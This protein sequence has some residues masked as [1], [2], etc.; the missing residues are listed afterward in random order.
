MI[1]IALDVTTSQ[2]TC[3]F[4]CQFIIFFLSMQYLLIPVHS[5]ILF[6]ISVAQK[7]IFGKTNITYYVHCLSHFHLLDETIQAEP[8]PDRRWL[9]KKHMC[10]LA[11]WNWAIR[12]KGE[13]VI[14]HSAKK[15][16][17]TDGSTLKNTQN[18][19]RLRGEQNFMT[20]NIR[21]KCFIK[22]RYK[23]L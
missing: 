5:H 17:I 3:C 14:G 9:W 21:A 20:I 4:L 13:E 18:P 10:H 12:N 2:I 11:L 23:N 22:S 6:R 15:M 7:T 8:K 19:H 1:Y 16:Q